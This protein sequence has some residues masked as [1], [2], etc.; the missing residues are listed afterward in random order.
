MACNPEKSMKK[1]SKLKYL[2]FL[3][4]VMLCNTKH[5]ILQ[6]HLPE[7]A[8]DAAN[9]LLVDS[10]QMTQSDCAEEGTVLQCDEN[11]VALNIEQLFTEVELNLVGEIYLAA[12]QLGKYPQPL[13]DL[14]Q[15]QLKVN[16]TV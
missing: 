13:P 15:H 3:S 5:H 12:L 16:T 4:V 10:H 1:L 6:A 7:L 8:L 14:H 9:W 11:S 2:P